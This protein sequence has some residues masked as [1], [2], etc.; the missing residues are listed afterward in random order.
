MET[1]R[2]GMI[3]PPNTRA[4]IID[5]LPA[6]VEATTVRQIDARKRNMD[7]DVKCTAKSRMKCRI[8]L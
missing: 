7:I 1:L 5:K 3:K 6:V 2:F 8:N 4:Y